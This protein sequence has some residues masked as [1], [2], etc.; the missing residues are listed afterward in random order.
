MDLFF[1]KISRKKSEYMKFIFK[2]L[3]YIWIGY[4]L[5]ALCIPLYVFL[6]KK[7]TN[8][9][10]INSFIG[11]F[12]PILIIFIPVGIILFPQCA[13][14]G[15]PFYKLLRGQ[16]I[17]T[18]KISIMRK[19]VMLLW[20]IYKEI[21]ITAVSGYMGYLFYY[22]INVQSDGSIIRNIFVI[23]PALISFILTWNL[24]GQEFLKLK[25]PRNVRFGIGV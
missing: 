10:L 7:F 21:I 13:L 12:I 14:Q 3:A 19:I 11:D 9:I 23:I 17:S 8:S 22:M 16:K 5:I 4:E 1:I 2:W 6:F 20:F 15:N 24:Q 25:I 18:L